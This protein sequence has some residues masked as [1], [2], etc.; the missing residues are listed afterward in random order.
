MNRKL[1]EL[2]EKYVAQRKRR[3]RLLKTVTALALVVAICTS[4]VLMMPGLT[5]AAETYCGL[6]EHTHTADCYVDELTCLISEREA[7]TVFTDIMRCSFEPH[8]HSSDCY[9]AQGELSC[10]Y[11]DGYIHE[12]DEKCYDSNGVL[13]CTLEESD[14]QAHGCLL[15]LG[16]AADLH[17]AGKRGA[18]PHGCVLSGKRTDLRS[19]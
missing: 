4:Y 14:A 15:Q 9:N 1:M 2:A 7:E 17:A 6:E 11:W 13:I 8:R 16:E 12:H 3:M 5:M 19:V 18:H 10:G